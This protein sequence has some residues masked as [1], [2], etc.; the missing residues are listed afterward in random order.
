MAAA[1]ILVVDDEQN[2]LKSWSRTLRLA[3]Y[4]V[5][6]AKNGDEALRECDEHH[7]D[8]V[9]LD[10]L[11]PSMTG[12][13]LLRRIRKKLPFVRSIIVSG[14]IDEHISEVEISRK[15][16]E[17]VEADLYL[18][19]PVSNESLRESV[20]TLLES[21]ETAQSWELM[22]RRA[23]DAGKATIAS[24]RGASRDLKK[25]GKRKGKR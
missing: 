5:R 17:T 16:R 6:I 20:R 24:A 2:V 23:K 1:K 10:F 14:K 15:L 25:L 22:A 19:K 4:A 8:L 21:R 3:G 12:V 13:E 18:H 9:M 11:M 7:F